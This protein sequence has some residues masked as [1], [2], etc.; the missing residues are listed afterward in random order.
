MQLKDILARELRIWVGIN[1]E[2]TLQY[3]GLFNVED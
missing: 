2:M 3:D 1:E